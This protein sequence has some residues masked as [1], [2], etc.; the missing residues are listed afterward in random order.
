M[1]TTRTL[2]YNEVI[3]YHLGNRARRFVERVNAEWDYYT[4]HAYAQA[5]TGCLG[6]AALRFALEKLAYSRYARTL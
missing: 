5:N 3:F 4:H 6:R 2:T 1:S